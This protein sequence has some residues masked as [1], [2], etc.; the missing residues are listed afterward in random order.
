MYYTWNIQYTTAQKFRVTFQTLKTFW[1]EVSYVKKYNWPHLIKNFMFEISEEKYNYVNMFFIP[2]HNCIKMAQKWR[3]CN[4][5]VMVLPP[6][7]LIC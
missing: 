3:T 5:Y 4:K 6:F 1:S 2:K 7:I